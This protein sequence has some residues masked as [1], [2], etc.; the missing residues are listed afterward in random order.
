[1]A[2]S[3]SRENRWTAVEVTGLLLLILL[4]CSSMVQVL[5]SKTSATFIKYGEP[6]TCIGGS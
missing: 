3:Q 6:G 1:M 5:G 4:L 2:E